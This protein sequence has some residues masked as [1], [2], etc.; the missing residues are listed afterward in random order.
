MFLIDLIFFI[1]RQNP[2]IPTDHVIQAHLY[3]EIVIPCKPA[4]KDFKVEIFK[5]VDE[6]S[7]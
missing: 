4:S 1:D 6:V 2:L 5:S 3:E 7:Q